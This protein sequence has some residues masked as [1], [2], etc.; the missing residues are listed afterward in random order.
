M[1]LH[2]RRHFNPISVGGDLK[3]TRYCLWKE[4]MDMDKPMMKAYEKVS[5]QLAGIEPTPATDDLRG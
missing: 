5:Y 3:T 2:N 4:F 1:F